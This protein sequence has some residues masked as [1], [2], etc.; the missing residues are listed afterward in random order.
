MKHK[1]D[2]DSAAFSPDARYLATASGDKT[3]RIWLLGPEDLIAEVASRLTRNLTYREWRGYLPDEPYRKTCPNLPIHPSFVEA[4]KDLAK[5]GDTE[6]ALAIFRRALEIEPTLNL[7][8]EKEAQS[9][10][11]SPSDP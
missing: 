1:S 7:D 10:A 4:G 2:V 5:K 11:P 9:L 6:G 8:P 3:A